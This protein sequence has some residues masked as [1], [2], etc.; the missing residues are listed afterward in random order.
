VS[1]FQAEH[2]RQSKKVSDNANEKYGSYIVKNQTIF[3]KQY[4]NYHHIPS[5]INQL[6]YINQNIT[7]NNG[8]IKQLPSSY[9]NSSVQFNFDKVQPS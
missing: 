9:F 8:G 2:K 4:S 7:N 6:S 1:L 5:V 3:D